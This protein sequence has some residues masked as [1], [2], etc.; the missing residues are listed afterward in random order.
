MAVVVIYHTVAVGCS[1][2]AVF[3]AVGNVAGQRQKR[4]VLQLLKERERR[5]KSCFHKIGNNQGMTQNQS[6]IANNRYCRSQTKSTA[7]DIDVFCST[8]KKIEHNKNIIRH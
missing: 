2:A 1:G 3:V 5:E 8:Y 6:K 4:E 7:E